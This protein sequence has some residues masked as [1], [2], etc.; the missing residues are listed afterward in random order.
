MFDSTP[1]HATKQ[2][3]IPR[4]TKLDMSLS[5]IQKKNIIGCELVL[6]VQV[7]TK[8]ISFQVKL[9]SV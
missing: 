6:V 2:I 9:D 3:R 8:V 5:E 7:V 1:K 4:T